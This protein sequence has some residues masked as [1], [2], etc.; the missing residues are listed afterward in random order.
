MHT[1]EDEQRH[2]RHQEAE[3]S[4]IEQPKHQ[5]GKEMRRKLRK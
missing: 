4:E 5:Q 1:Q 2:K 3:G